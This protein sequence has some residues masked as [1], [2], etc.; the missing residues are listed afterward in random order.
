MSAQ[1]QSAKDFINRIAALSPERRALLIDRLPPLSFGQQ[2]LWF[3]DQMGP[4]SALNVIALPVRLQGQLDVSVLERSLSEVMRRHEILRTCFPVFDGRPAQLVLPAQP[5]ALPLH[6]LTRLSPAERETEVRR[7]IAA[8]VNRPFNLHDGPVMRGQLLRLGIEDHVVLLAAHHIVFDGWSTGVLIREVSA[9][10]GAYIRGATPPLGELKLQYGDYARWQRQWLQGDVVARQMEY[11]RKQLA[12]LPPLLELPTDYARPAT[13]SFNGGNETVE[14]DRDL[15]DALRTLSRNEN[16]T[17]FMTVL[18]GFQALLYRYT[19]NPDIPVGSPIAGRADASMESL[20]GCFVNTIVLRAKLSGGMSFKELLGSVREVALDAHAH[21]DL[22]FEWLVEALRPE[23]NLSYAPL[24]QV[25]FALQNAPIRAAQLPGLMM[26]ILEYE[27]NKTQ[28]FD[29]TLIL[30]ESERGLVGSFEYD[31][32]LFEAG[33]IKRMIDHFAALL[34][35]VTADPG[36]KLA[37]I[38]FLSQAERD[39][40]LFDWNRTTADYPSEAVFH[41]LFEDHVALRP[42]ATAVVCMGNR[43][44]YRQLNERANCLAR[45]LAER[46]V[47]PEVVVALLAE[48]GIDLLTAIIAVFKAGGAYLPLDPASPVPRLAQ[49]IERSRTPL[50]LVAP[51]FDQIIARVNQSLPDGARP[52]VAPIALA[53]SSEWPSENPPLRSFPENL[54]YVIYTSGSTGAPKGAMIG[55]RGMIN[56]LYAKIAGL[57]LTSTDIIAQTA[58]PCFDISVWQFLSALLVGGRVEIFP[59]EVAH[60]GARLLEAA[61]ESGVTI[62][63]SVPSLLR[64]TLDGR[65]RERL[66]AIQLPLLR[67]MIMTGEALP[68]DLCRDWFARYPRIPLLNAYGPTECSD[69]VT[70][71]MIFE[72]LAESMAQTPIGLPIINTQL[73]ILDENLDVAPRGCRGELY[74]GGD[75]VG[76]GYLHDGGRTAEVFIP[77][78]LSGSPSARLYRTGDLARYLPDGTIQYLGRVD[79]QVKVRGFRIE[80][81]EIEAVLNEHPQVRDTVVVDHDVNPDGKS[82]VAY[83]VPNLDQLSTGQPGEPGQEA[84]EERQIE[85]WLAIYNDVYREQAFYSQD[86]SLSLRVWVNSYT[87]QPFPEEEIFESVEDSTRRIL[88]LSPSRVLEIGCGTGLILFRVAPHCASYW[89]SDISPAAIHVLR[90][91]LKRSERSL[92][93]IKLLNRAADDFAEL[94]LE[95]FDLVVINE[96]AQY[97]SGD[98]LRRVIEGAV[99]VVRPG[100]AIFIGGVRSLPLLETFHASVQLAQSSPS[101]TVMRFRHQTQRRM[102]QEKEC[103]FD[104]EFF[105]ALQKHLPQISHVNFELKGGR[106]RNEFTKFRYD[107]VLHIGASPRVAAEVIWRDW[108][109]DGLTLSDAR[110]TL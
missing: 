11:W 81:G 90:E 105:L 53:A 87:G 78:H 41:T 54:A 77:D 58:S 56:H 55:Q 35:S 50:A 82:L 48:R 69:D 5:L 9:L 64:A 32:E 91:R 102:S 3:F 72:P 103:L 65:Q 39:Q 10:Y 42:E 19:G 68:P 1:K 16:A 51:E 100:G 95:A 33:S 7:L 108:R 17:L 14:L 12:D 84:L 107:V 59:D 45:V 22:P 74:V 23:R 47:G 2:R 76:R 63:E 71:H 40:L 29:L 57:A 98:Y 8:E 28:G 25:M 89:G 75:G 44:S 83:V 85:S 70:H 61:E 13:Q 94:P 31:S 34:R 60:D 99:R 66:D 96:V 26:S 6:D 37:H 18:A 88:S 106:H 52:D 24:F 20:L 36:R 110:Q 38:E 104:P 80:L 62:L 86:E 15:C 101:E 67:W 27:T 79:H 92:P 93:E 30:V 21:Q 73:Y 109:K 4:G 43:L 49:M 97:L 46:N